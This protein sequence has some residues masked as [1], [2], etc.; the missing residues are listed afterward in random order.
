MKKDEQTQLT[1]AKIENEIY[2]QISNVDTMRP[3]FMSIL[4]DSNHWM[5]IGSNGG[6]SAGRKDAENSLFPYYTDD[7]IIESAELTGSKTIV[8]V[9]KNGKSNLWEPFS[10]RYANLY[11]LTRNLYKSIHG[12]KIIFEEINQDL[13]LAFQYQWTSSNVYGFIKTSKL[14]NAS[15]SEVAI[16]LID[17][18][19]NIIPYGVGSALQSKTS[20]LV[21]AYKRSEL[22]QENGIGVF[23]LSAI[24]VDKAEPSEALKANIAWSIGID[25]AK[26]LLS[27]PLL[28]STASEMDC[29]LA[30]KLT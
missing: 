8:R 4:S 20:N 22:D 12:N 14:T 18:I 15:T 19:Q 5:F 26:H 21:D 10:I 9:L 1:E 27:S 23:S 25:D 13:E 30:K 7:K 16:S 17:G 6:L 28:N 24:I 3:F 11:Q 2:Y 29:P